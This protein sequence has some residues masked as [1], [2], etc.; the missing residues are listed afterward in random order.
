MLFFV[1]LSK[2]KN[3][4]FSLIFNALNL[5]EKKEASFKDQDEN[6]ATYAKKIS[7]TESEIFW[8]EK[9]EKIIAKIN[10]LNPSPGVWFRHKG[11]RVKIIHADLVDIKGPAGEVLSDDLIVGCKDKAIRIKKIQKEGKKILDT[12][13]FLKGYKI[14]KGEM[15][16]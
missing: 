8:F 6:L 3:I 13:D 15:L 7:K 1:F 10:G 4:F 16:L 14:N 12:T 5:L 9:A 2:F 11:N